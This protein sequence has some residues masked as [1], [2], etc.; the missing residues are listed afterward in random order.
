MTERLYVFITLLTVLLFIAGCW[1]G[2]SQPV[3]PPKEKMPEVEP[4]K[5]KLPKEEQA[6]TKVPEAEAP[7]EK[8]P[9]AKPTKPKPR[10]SVSFHDKCAD[11]LKNHVDDKGR[12]DYKGLKQKKLD[13]KKL[14]DEF[15][16][17]DPD[18]YNSWPREDKIALWLNAYNIQ[19]LKIIVDN[20]PIESSRVLRIFWGPNSIRHIKG[21]WDKYKLIVMDEEFTLSEID[22]R[23]FHRE[24]DEP[25]IFFAV[26]HAS[27]SS[28]PLRSEPYYGQ[29]LY[30]QL[31]DQIKKFLSSPLA[32][33]IDRKSQIVYL[34]AVLQPTWYGKEFIRS[35]GTD[36][37]FKDR[38]P[39]TRA[40]LN[41]LTNYISGQD[42]SFLELENYSVEYIKYDWMLNDGS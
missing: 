25:R 18:E 40:V 31:D 38:Q 16:K 11:I 23:F 3:E 21:I 19:M 10:P 8:A 9:E 26:S 5:E 4:L 34:S 39:P 37:K 42:V 1:P 33:R 22:R 15:A 7:K 27:F 6:K 2:P 24:F 28:P 36:K 17:L 32:F 12:V 20:Y 41:F 29:K 14:L 35:Y 30:R 13:L